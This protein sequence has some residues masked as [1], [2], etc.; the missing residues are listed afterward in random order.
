MKAFCIK[1]NKIIEWDKYMTCCKCSTSH[2]LHCKTYLW[3]HSEIKEER[4]EN[5]RKLIHSF[6]KEKLERILK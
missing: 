4:R 3:V 1:N 5:M 6:R 2:L